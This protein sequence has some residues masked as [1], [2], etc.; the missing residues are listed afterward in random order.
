M[1][2]SPALSVTENQQAPGCRKAA[3]ALG[4][5][6]SPVLLLLRQPRPRRR[7]VILGRREADFFTGAVGTILSTWPRI[8]G[9]SADERGI[10]GMEGPLE[11]G[12]Q[13]PRKRAATVA[14]RIARRCVRSMVRLQDQGKERKRVRDVGTAQKESAEMTS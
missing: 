4:V 10:E 12:M 9:S 8:G 6:S 13:P 11:F 3:S 5:R 2:R 7:W 14:G 1:K